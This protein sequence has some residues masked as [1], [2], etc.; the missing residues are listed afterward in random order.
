MA[1]WLKLE[2]DI[3]NSRKIK[4]IRKFPEGDSLFTLWIGMLCMAMEKESQQLYV[5]HEVPCTPEDL[6]SLLDLDHKTVQM[7]LELF[8]RYD[9]ISVNDD[10]IIDVVGIAHHQSL[11]KLDRTRDLTKERMRRYR[12]RQSS[13]AVTRNTVT[14]TPTDLDLEGDKKYS[15]EFVEFWS[16]Y[17]RKERKAET[18]DLYDSSAGSVEERLSA[19]KAY[20][21][22]IKRDQPE[23]KYIMLPTT[24]FAQGR[25][26][27]YVDMKPNGTGGR[28]AEWQCA[29]CGK[30]HTNTSDF[31]PICGRDRF[32]NG[33]EE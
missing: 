14:V 21:A 7:G 18:K 12:G 22:I 10:G 3:L 6:A 4:L 25:W 29:E 17:P 1:P 23:T 8:Q 20:A 13:Y 2:V 11:D 27:D 33:G 26:L 16:H 31:C 24:F 32:E 9:M 19:V 30:K 5:A 15:S 28:Y